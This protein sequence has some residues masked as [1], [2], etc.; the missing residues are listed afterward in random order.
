MSASLSD[1]EE[2]D[3]SLRMTGQLVVARGRSGR[4]RLAQ[5]GDL[6]ETLGLPCER[7]DDRR[8]RERL[9]IATSAPGHETE[10]PAALRLPVAGVLNPGRLVAGLSAT[11]QRH[12][13]RIIE[14]AKVVSLSRGT[15][16]RV[17][18]AD[19]REVLARHVVVAS[20]G[21]AST[22]NLQHGRLIPLHLRV[23]LTEPLTPAQLEQLGWPNREGVIDSRRVFNYFRLTDDNRILF[24]GGR[25]QYVWGGQLA[26]RP[27]EGPDLDRLVESFRHQFPALGNLAIARSWTGV[28]AYTLDNLPVVARV[29]GHERVIFA[30]GWCGHGIAA[31]RL[32][33]TLGAGADR[34]WRTPRGLALVAPLPPPRPPGGRPL[35]GGAVLRVGAGNVGPALM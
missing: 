24:G 15:P 2:I 25:P 35:A 16:A 1:R 10:G 9:S 21:Y 8:L 11:V 28:I 19:H 30:G 4:R 27:A 29:P 5:Q 17:Q 12:G 14:G 20:S 6:M 3:A 7:L 32:L 31:E 13:G 34:R 18:L 22:L 23:L 33:G 26:D